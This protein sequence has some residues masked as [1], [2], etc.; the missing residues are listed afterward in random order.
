[1]FPIFPSP[2]IIVI[3]SF[4]PLFIQP[5]PLIPKIAQM[6][7]LHPGSGLLFFFFALI[8]ER[9]FVVIILKVLKQ[10]EGGKISLP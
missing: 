4:L 9:P 7:A 8:P 3:F 10:H 5:S 2:H 6:E 1:M